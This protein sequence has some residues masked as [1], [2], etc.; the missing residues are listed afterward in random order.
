MELLQRL[1]QAIAWLGGAL[2]AL[3]AICYATGYYAFHAHLTMLGL[4]RV[5]DFQHE[6]MLLEGARFFFT[7]TA[8]LLQMVLA[9]GAALVS[10]LVLYALLGEIGPL[11]RGWRRLGE[12]LRDRRAALDAARPAL[13]GTLALSA[14][15]LLLIAHTNRF[16]YP[17]LALGRIDSLLF[18]PGVPATH[19]CA[20][21]IPLTDIG[22]TPAV[23]A[24]L[25]MQGERC[26]SFLLG[27]FRRLLD[28][29]LV[30]LIALRLS[31]SLSF[32][33]RPPALA[34]AFRL[35]L[36]VYAMVYTLLLP[37]GFGILVR[38]AV[39]PVASIEFKGGAVIT[40]NLMTRN[41][42]SLLL[43]LPGERK[44]VW[45]PSETIAT[46]QVTGQDNLFS[47]PEGGAK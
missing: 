12:W 31:F 8:H 25:L 10:L 34:R 44:A 3:T 20:A 43:W 29:Y 16:F 37:I 32:P 5:V 26:S 7:V 15:V 18:R 9:L 1:K 40:G 46:V 39:Y 42:K 38:A 4:G 47:H 45:Y 17:L 27:E 24:S 36:A 22:L 35:V 11:G 14:L 30:L 21:L 41:D 2:A 23:A 28:G 33:L 6:E 13:V 19:D